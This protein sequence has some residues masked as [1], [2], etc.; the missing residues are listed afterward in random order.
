MRTPVF[1]IVAIAILSVGCDRQTPPPPSPRLS[2]EAGQPFGDLYR[3]AREIQ[4]STRV[5]VSYAAFGELVRKLAVTADV[6]RDVAQTEAE[7]AV[8][9]DIDKALA[10]YQDALAAWGLKVSHGAV[11][12]TYHDAAIPVLVERYAIKPYPTGNYRA[13]D[14]LRAAWAVAGARV[15]D[16]MKRFLPT[17]VVAK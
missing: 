8:L 11:L 16:A 4:T 1:A 12:A 3:T 7:L 2:L 13:D 14:I 6:A 17:P 15:D 10:A 9:A 5:G